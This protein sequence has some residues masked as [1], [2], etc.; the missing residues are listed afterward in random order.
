MY[1]LVSGESVTWRYQCRGLHSDTHSELLPVLC[2]ALPVLMFIVNVWCHFWMP[3]LTVIVIFSYFFRPTW[4]GFPICRC[5]PD[6]FAITLESCQKSRRILDVFSPSQ[7]FGGLSK[8]M[9]L[10]SPLPHAARHVAWKK[11]LWGTPTSP[12][13]IGAH[14]PNF[15]P[16]FKFSRLFFFWGGGKGASH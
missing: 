5:V 9:P 13:V 6:I 7:F 14:T 3:V 15:K 16:I 12:K 11:F 1:N 2:N 8:V 4:K 10:L